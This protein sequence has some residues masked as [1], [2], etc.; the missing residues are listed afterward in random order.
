MSHHRNS[1]YLPPSA[2]AVVADDPMLVLVGV[3]GLARLGWFLEQAV[4][5]L[6]THSPSVVPG[7][8]GRQAPGRVAGSL[9]PVPL[10]EVEPRFSH[11]GHGGEARLGEKDLMV[12]T[13]GEALRSY[14]E[15]AGLSQRQLARQVPIS[16]TTLSRYETDRQAVDPAM[17][18]R[19]DELVGA[20]GALRP[21]LDTR[22]DDELELIEMT[23]RAN[24]SSI[25]A[26]TLAELETTT[27]ELCRA[28]STQDPAA[29]RGRTTAHLR[30]VLGLLDGRTTLDQHRELLVRAGW[31]ALLLGCVAYDIGDRL[32]ADQA[33]R[34]AYR[35]GDQA[36]HGQIMAW[37]YEL[38]AWYAL[39]EG[40]YRDAVELSERGL[41][42]AGES[43]AAVQLTVQAS[44][45]YA[46]LG[47]VQA[48]A[49][50]E[51]GRKILERLPRPDTPE[52]HFV[53]DPDKHTF[54]VAKILT[55]LGKDE[56]AAEEHAREVIRH[57][58]QAGRWPMRLAESQ[59]NL[60]SI[61]G[62]RGDLDEAV[63]LATSALQVER[64]SG[65]LLP[66]AEE[67]LDALADRYPKERLVEEYRERLV[68][69]L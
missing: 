36:G 30:Y 44:H 61:A 39:V 7:H 55:S 27:D 8:T 49:T 26:E 18:D 15:Q 53:F 63:G 65:G 5:L 20:G 41:Q 62:R 21:L 51:A 38:G 69:A 11:R 16:Q 31:D 4:L 47:D 22:H 28:Y 43:S 35:L 12:E 3:P 32:A 29:L 42:H 1:T 66:H 60:G 33:R 6:L 34:M 2:A 40:R 25:G 46:R 24:H 9:G 23:R 58:E 48:R 10:A 52:H 13:F 17:A 19:L 54:Y 37:S 64:R 59:L 56:V 14:R 50:L 57:C 67:L 45:G 68:A